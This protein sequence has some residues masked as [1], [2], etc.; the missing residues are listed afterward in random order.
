MTRGG[1]LYPEDDGARPDL[2]DVPNRRLPLHGGSS[3]NPAPTSHLAGVCLNEASTRVQAILPSGLPLA[4]GRP[5]GTGRP[6]AFPRASN[7]ADQEPDDARQGGDRPSSTD[8]KQ[9]SR[10]QSNLQSCVFTH[11][12]AT[13]RRN[14]LG[15]SAGSGA[16][17]AFCP[18]GRPYGNVPIKA[19]MGTLGLW[20]SRAEMPGVAG[21]IAA[22]RAHILSASTSCGASLAIPGAAARG[23]FVMDDST[24]L[25][26]RSKTGSE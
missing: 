18:A 1:P 24:A 9:R 10:H 11:M 26:L 15:G 21:S 3:F 22:R 12:R 4:C 5:D 19:I 23:W 16:S 13:S 8:P 14:G 6:R 17:L 7:P 25:L 20:S 2:G